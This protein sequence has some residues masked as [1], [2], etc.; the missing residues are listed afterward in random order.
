MPCP[1]VCFPASLAIIERHWKN[2][3]RELERRKSVLSGM[4]VQARQ[5][6][7]RIGVANKKLKERLRELQAVFQVWQ[8]LLIS[9]AVS[10]A[11]FTV[12]AFA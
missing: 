11:H 6:D 1:S 3:K 2:K 12:A 5:L 7:E 9:K 10:A 4:N 8:Q